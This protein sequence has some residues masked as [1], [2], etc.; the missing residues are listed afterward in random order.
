MDFAKYFRKIWKKIPFRKIGRVFKIVGLV[1]VIILGIIGVGAVTFDLKCGLGESTF[2]PIAENMSF[3]RKQVLKL[4]DGYQRPEEGT[5]LTFPEWYLVF[6]PQE[7]AEFIKTNPPSEFPYFASIGQFWNGYCQ[8][9]SMTKNNY[10]FN[11]GNHLMI[12][13]IGTSFTVEYAMK[14]IYENTFGRLTEWIS[15]DKK[16]AEDEYEAK[17]AKEYGDFIPN[18]PFYEFTYG[19]KLVGMWGKTNL[20]DENM[21][22]K[23][24]RKLSFSFEYGV[25]AIYGWLIGL[26]THAVYGVADEVVYAIVE[27]ATEDVFQDSRVKKVKDL[28]E[29]SYVI[30][31]PHYQGF[32]DVAPLLAKQNV[33]FK[34]IAGNNEILISVIKPNL[35]LDELKGVNYSFEMNIL[36]KP[37]FK[38]LVFQARVE[39]L[40]AILQQIGSAGYILEHLYDY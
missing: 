18:K 2:R 16:T 19:D 7:Y 32:T 37:G 3:E 28:G 14:G 9:Y 29:G 20:W 27:R 23:W 8:V 15:A 24:E 35:E 17:V 5:Y 39:D 34:D 11:V 40:S 12:G 26:G 6:N 10:D 36:T 30:T 13:V 1:F 21:L 25:K 38:R 31:L 22:R 4:I 33:E